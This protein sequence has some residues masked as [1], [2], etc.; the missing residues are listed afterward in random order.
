[1]KWIEQK[2]DVI[3]TDWEAAETEAKMEF[4]KEMRKLA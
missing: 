3:H 4:R 2:N 1:M